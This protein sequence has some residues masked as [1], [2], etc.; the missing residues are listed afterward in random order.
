VKRQKIRLRKIIFILLGKR[1]ST[2]DTYFFLFIWF[3]GILSMI[4]LKICHSRVL[5]YKA[6]L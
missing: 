1:T 4:I 5:G 3:L 2:F 6:R